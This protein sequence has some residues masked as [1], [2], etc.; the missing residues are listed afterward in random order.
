MIIRLISHKNNRYM[1]STLHI[2]VIFWWYNHHTLLMVVV[3][4]ITLMSTGSRGIWLLLQMCCWTQSISH[5]F[6]YIMEELPNGCANLV[7]STKHPF[8]LSQMFP[9]IKW[10]IISYTYFI[11]HVFSTCHQNVTT[12]R[13]TQSKHDSWVATKDLKQK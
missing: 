11:M 6:C 5:F 10:S 12:V 8:A 2:I 13:P 4:N 3:Q 1:S 7:Q 9:A